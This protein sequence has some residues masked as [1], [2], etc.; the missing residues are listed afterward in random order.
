MVINWGEKMKILILCVLLLAIGLTYGCQ[1][2]QDVGSE[3]LYF[4]QEI[5]DSYKGYLAIYSLP[6]YR[7]AKSVY[8]LN[9]R[10]G[11][12]AYEGDADSIAR[13]TRRALN[14]CEGSCEIFAINRKI[15]W[16]NFTH[17]SRLD[18]LAKQFEK[19]GSNP[20]I[21]YSRDSFKLSDFQKYQ[22]EY[23]LKNENGITSNYNRAYAV[24]SDGMH[25]GRSY[26]KK[27]GSDR[28]ITERIAIVDCNAQTQ[29]N[30]CVVYAYNDK[31]Y[32][33]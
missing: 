27:R 4:P 28:F 11:A 17:K 1:T 8:A 18:D 13:A 26:M 21:Y 15:V 31:I 29:S 32:G 24:S 30:D 7:S 25:Y 6:K 23:T 3:A 16:K 9:A 19:I 10:T 22:Y 33:Q 2:T 12:A 5:E 14:G 20:L